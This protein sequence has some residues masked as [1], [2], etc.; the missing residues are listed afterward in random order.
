MRGSDFL[1]AHRQRDQAPRA[2]RKY[3][4]RVYTAVQRM[5]QRHGK[6]FFDAD[7]VHVER[8]PRSEKVSNESSSSRETGN[9]REYSNS[10]PRQ[11]APGTYPRGEWSTSS[12]GTQVLGRDRQHARFQE[13]DVRTG[14]GLAHDRPIANDEDDFDRTQREIR[15]RHESESRSRNRSRG[16]FLSFFT[17]KRDDS[18]QRSKDDQ[19]ATVY[20]RLLLAGASVPAAKAAYEKAYGET[21]DRRDRSEYSR[22]AGRSTP[23]TE[24]T[25][26]EY[27]GPGH[28]RNRQPEREDR[29]N[30]SQGDSRPSRDQRQPQPN[31]PNAVDGIRG[32]LVRS[33]SQSSFRRKRDASQ[34]KGHRMRQTMRSSSGR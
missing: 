20:E 32:A 22:S 23:S 3:Q 10:D 14:A 18:R 17:G 25:S 29:Y 19:V 24:P 1:A 2:D 12:I 5:F 34:G 33:A 7:G 4:V 26:R 15:E 27:L 30:Y 31:R 21:N 9:S 8:S 6:C 16:G 11:R 28:G 13:P